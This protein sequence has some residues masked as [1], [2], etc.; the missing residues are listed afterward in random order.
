MVKLK[1]PIVS[2]GASGTIG[3]V[4]TASSWKGRSYLKAKSIP[5]QP[6]SGLQISARLLMGFLS[7]RWLELSAADQDSWI[8]FPTK[9]NLPPYNHYLSTNL[10]RWGRL[11]GVVKNSSQA[12][13][14][15]NSA[16][17]SFII[18]GGVQHVLLGFTITSINDGWA[19]AWFRNPTAGFTIGRANMVAMQ[20][21]EAVAT[22]QTIDSPLAPGTYF[23]RRGKFTV[24]GDFAQAG[25][26]SSTTVT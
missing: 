20:H 26:E 25:G 1:G 9:E 15:T 17:S 11:E 12:G 10:E 13:G 22:F 7:A 18:T 5:K 8:D 16:T 4:V 23:Y 6:D 19:L 3:D 21:A 14:G 2:L 24:Q